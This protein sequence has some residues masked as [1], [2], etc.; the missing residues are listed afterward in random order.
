MILF[1]HIIQVLALPKKI[2]FWKCA[3]ALEGIEG[4]RIRCVLVHGDHARK[5]CMA[6]VQHLPEK[7]FG[8]VCVT[9]GAQHE[10]Q[11]GTRRVDGPVKV[12]PFLFDL[13]VRFIHAVRI[14]GG[15]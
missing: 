8:C 9:G 13:D 15:P 3:V 6:R 10:V 11:R 12:V 2:G 7:L 1:D 5:R 4:M 14:V